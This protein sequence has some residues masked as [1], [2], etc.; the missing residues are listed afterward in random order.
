MVL[1]EEAACSAVNE[2]VDRQ[3]GEDCFD[4]EAAKLVIQS[5]LRQS[6]RKRELEPTNLPETEETRGFHAYKVVGGTND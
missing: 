5:S 4:E 3:L 1:R 6:S 2:A